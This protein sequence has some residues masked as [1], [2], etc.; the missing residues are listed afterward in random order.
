MPNLV[1][2]DI[3]EWMRRMEFRITDLT[4]RVSTLIPGDI[5]DGVD[6]DGYKSTGRWRRPSAVG[7]TTALHYPFAGASGTLEVY[8]EPTN[9]Q[10]HQIWYDRSGTIWSRWW[11]N[12]TWSAWVV[13]TGDDTGWVAVPMSTNWQDFSGSDVE[14]RRIGKLVRVRGRAERLTSNITN[15]A[16]TMMTLPVGFRPSR[17]LVQTGMTNGEYVT[18]GASAGT[19][20]THAMMGLSTVT[21]PMVRLVIATSGTIEVFAP[22]GITILV[23]R[24]VSVDEVAFFID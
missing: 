24:W 2:Q 6:L 10:V 7:T 16:S 21:G 9:P 20:H 11:N 22:P 14:V 8:W 5:A 15:V 12:V 3:R 17:T 1:P 13:A 23:G 18:G 4:R 19:A